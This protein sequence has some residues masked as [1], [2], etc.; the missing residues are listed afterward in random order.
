MCVWAV[1][2]AILQ[3]ILDQEVQW[4]PN[5]VQKGEA[6]YKTPGRY[7]TFHQTPRSSSSSPSSGGDSG[8]LAKRYVHPKPQSEQSFLGFVS[9][10]QV[11]VCQGSRGRTE[12]MEF[13]KG[14]SS[15]MGGNKVLLSPGHGVEMDRARDWAVEVYKGKAAPPEEK[16]EDILELSLEDEEGEIAIKFLAFAVFFF[17]K[18]TT[19]VFVQRHAECLGYQGASGHRKLGDNSFKLEF[20]SAEEKQSVVEGGPWRHKGGTLIVVH[21]DGLARLSEVKIDSI[22]MWVRLYDLPAALMNEAFGMQLGGQLG[23]F[24]KMDGRFPSYMRIRVLYPLEKPLQPE[25]KIKIKG[26]GVMAIMLRY[27]NVPHFCFSC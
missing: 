15:A 5:S 9:E 13:T 23:K 6:E 24:I 14:E 4:R 27:K 17:Q 22:Q 1:H 21:Y 20:A 8:E 18:A 7:P 16:E 3:D 19:E 2:S 11:D 10:G 25:L 26:R 12:S